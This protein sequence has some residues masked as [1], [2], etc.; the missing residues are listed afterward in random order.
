MKW[1]DAAEQ[2]QIF[3]LFTAHSVHIPQSL[4]TPALVAL[5]DICLI[6]QQSQQNWL[7]SLWRDSAEWR[8]GR[9][10]GDIERESGLDRELSIWIERA[11]FVVKSW[12]PPAD[13]WNSEVTAGASTLT[14]LNRDPS[15]VT[16]ASRLLLTVCHRA[17]E[18]GRKGHLSFNSDSI[19][20]FPALQLVL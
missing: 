14:D 2:T 19:F 8:K 18:C 16:S 5:A 3:C 4:R 12:R 9:G 13:C 1:E 15:Q 17:L 7:P 10:G 6:P 11:L 20:L